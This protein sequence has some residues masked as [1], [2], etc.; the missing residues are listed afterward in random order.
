MV[1]LKL[2]FI[3]NYG[4]IMDTILITPSNNGQ[5]A[6]LKSA[7][8]FHVTGL[9]IQLC[10]NKIERIGIEPD[11]LKKYQP[12]KWNYNTNLVII[13]EGGEVWLQHNLRKPNSECVK[14]TD[15]V[16]RYIA[17]KGKDTAIPTFE[18]AMFL[19]K[20]DV[21]ERI[22]NPFHLT[23]FEKLRTIPKKQRAAHN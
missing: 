12:G 3:Q 21:M 9:E 14:I 5:Q 22:K 19:S 15:M 23:N 1:M 11:L 4:G 8:F 6:L 2:L 17:I 16:I 10:N 20:D 13:T 7:G 18:N